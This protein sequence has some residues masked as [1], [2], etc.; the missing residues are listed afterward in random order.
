MKSAKIPLWPL[1]WALV[2]GLFLP[3]P[4]AALRVNVQPL[5]DSDKL[6]FSFD[7]GVLPE[8]SV[9][10][11]GKR[12]L[13]VTLPAGVWGSEARPGSKDFPGK[14]V[15]AI[16]VGDNTV[17]IDTRTDAFGFIR[18]PVP[19]KPQFLLQIYRDPIGARWRPAKHDTPAPAS[20]PAVAPA[21]APTAAQPQAAPALQA[22]QPQAQA[23]QAD[24]VEGDLPP[25]QGGAGDR[26][27]FFSVPYSV[28]TEVAPP[29][30][31]D[32]AV[33]Q[34]SLAQSDTGRPVTEQP[35]AVQPDQHAPAVPPSGNELRFKAVNKTAEEVKFA[36]LAGPDAGG[37]AVAE[38]V[39]APEGQA[40]F[41]VVTPPP[42]ESGAG[43]VVGGVTPPPG[44]QPVSQ[45][46]A[47]P[48]PQPLPRSAPQAAVL[49]VATAEVSGAGQAGGSVV[50]P[51]SVVPGAPP[52]EPTAEEAATVHVAVEPPAPDRQAQAVQS[53]AEQAAAPA[54]IEGAVPAESIVPAE[55]AAPAGEGS[56]EAPATDN[57]TLAAQAAREELKNQIYEAQTLM[58]N[59]NLPEAQEIYE[60]A[61][62]SPALDDAT[63]EEALYALADIK[64]QLNND[65]LADK[66]DEISQ[67]YLEAMNA[68]LHSNRVPHALLNLGLINLKVGNFPEAKAYFKLLQDKYPDDENIP[69]IS[70]YWGEYYYKKGD[71]KKAA[72]QFQYLIQT[73]PEHELVKQA[74]Y[75]LADSLDKTGFYDQ[76]YQII[77]Y[78]DKRWPDYYMENPE[79][80]RLAGGVE[81]RLGKWGEAKNHYFTFYNLNPEAK[82]ADVV[83]ARLGD[84]YI[85]QGEKGAAKQIYEKAV[86]D[87]PT[88]EGGL[89]AKMR[90]AEEGIYDDPTLPQMGDVF[91]RPYNKRPEVVYQ[92]IVKQYPDSPLA[93]VAQLKLAMWYAFNKQYPEALTAAQDLI[94][95]YPDSALADRARQLGDAVFAL[96]V[97][98]MVDE[99]LYG[100][101][102]RYWETYDFI[103]KK[104]TK[105]NDQTRLGVAM[106][107]WKVGQPEKALGLLRPYLQPRQTPGVSDKALGMAVNIYLDGLAWKEISDLVTMVKKNW[108]LDDKQLRQMDYARA[109]SLQNLG[110]EGAALPMWAELARDVKVDPA[111]RAYAMYY[112]AKSAMEQ[113]DLRRVFVYSQEA[114]SLLLQTGGDPEKIK[115]V[116]LMSIYS[117]ER[118]GR[119]GEA[120]KWA[121]EYDRYVKPDNPEW[122]ST[123]FKL[124]RIYRKAGAMD[125]WK[126]LLTDIIEKKPDSLQA[127]LAK[128]ELETY[129]LEQQAQQYAPAP[130]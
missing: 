78:I 109:M 31:Q 111:L 13:V 127:T 96:A 48:A 105:V 75:Y 65:S 60:K 61:L 45:P 66:F 57:A 63:R 43:E 54:P 28:R 121:R 115:D 51:P 22:A 50:P 82:G 67:A 79:F 108:K 23:V 26:K 52:P 69:S 100:R 95:K 36:E 72:D 112:M 53:P 81:M 49:P 123:R 40:A 99:G 73:Y 55:G 32:G 129:A 80:L 5:G 71:Y 120:L 87:Y 92:D 47:Q 88:S 25:E 29:P 118:S 4:A 10:R 11:D 35:I 8:M 124:A 119:Y 116:V 46:I 93:P 125:E 34:P 33:A 64:K 126:K 21:P 84:I 91:N 70:Y 130:Q 113:Q 110:E 85:R 106:S 37:S 77:D 83:L 101:V 3:H 98:G 30:G 2:A 122:A 19:G 16:R 56:A 74:A 76:A 42:G 38:P 7:A 104:D 12:S 90:L 44:A 103:G 62:L 15:K 41:G 18:I 117:T 102:V 94:E 17:E 9:Q 24:R 1:L 89:V 20:A 58:F 86:Q 68:N 59:G 97:P 14:L 6:T 39:A 128:S 27:P 114:L 107:Y